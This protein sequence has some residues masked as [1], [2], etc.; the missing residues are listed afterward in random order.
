MLN[1]Y[2]SSQFGAKHGVF[3]YGINGLKILPIDEYSR[4]E[5]PSNTQ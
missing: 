4:K 5:D 3:S 1:Y 2:L